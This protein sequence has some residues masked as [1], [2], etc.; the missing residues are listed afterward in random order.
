MKTINM[1]TADKQVSMSKPIKKNTCLIP[2]YNYNS[3]VCK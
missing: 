1:L 3:H 2:A